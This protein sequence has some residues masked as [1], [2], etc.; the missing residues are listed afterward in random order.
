MSDHL[1][2]FCPGTYDRLWA[3]K[4]DLKVVNIRLESLNQRL[5][6]LQVSSEPDSEQ[7]TVA[8]QKWIQEAQ[9]RKVSAESTI[10][11]CE[12]E[13]RTNRVVHSYQEFR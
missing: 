6:D 8:I 1:W 11:V 4:Q 3:A 12:R 9:G 2:G 13:I 5:R 7:R 10:N